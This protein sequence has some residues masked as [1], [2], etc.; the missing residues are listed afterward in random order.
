MRAAPLKTGSVDPAEFEEVDAGQD[1][2][3]QGDDADGEHVAA[4]G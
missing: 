2:D 1:D 4:P 3:E